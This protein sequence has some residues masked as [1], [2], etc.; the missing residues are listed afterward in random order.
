MEEFTEFVFVV[1]MESSDGVVY[2]VHD[3]K[4]EAEK[5]VRRNFSKS[6]AWVEEVPMVRNRDE[7]HN[8]KQ[9]IINL[10]DQLKARDSLI[11]S[12]ERKF[13]KLEK[14]L[15]VYQ[16]HYKFPRR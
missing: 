8:L 13:N 10:Q 9:E 4:E 16:Q 6:E 11:K 7:V 1:M 15:K 12:W 5:C 3:D 2:C 14:V